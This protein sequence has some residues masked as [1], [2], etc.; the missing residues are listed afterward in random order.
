[1]R[2]AALSGWLHSKTLHL[3]EMAPRRTT[4]QQR[5]GG[6]HQLVKVCLPAL[7]LDLGSK[8]VGEVGG[9]VIMKPEEGEA[10]SA[11]HNQLALLPWPAV[12]AG[13]PAALGYLSSP[14]PP[15]CRPCPA[16]D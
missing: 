3:V 6:G 11:S 1:M 16:P 9:K 7:A 13:P 4:A 2:S 5:S 12:L 15:A 14:A 10:E 8:S